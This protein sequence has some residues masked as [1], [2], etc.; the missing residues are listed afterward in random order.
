M[1]ERANQRALLSVTNHSNRHYPHLCVRRWV[2]ELMSQANKAKREL[3]L[4]RLDGRLAKM[5]A[6]YYPLLVTVTS[7]WR[8]LMVGWQRCKHVTNRY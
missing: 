4:A 1:G 3:E 6:R 8:G 7:S 2:S 5:Q